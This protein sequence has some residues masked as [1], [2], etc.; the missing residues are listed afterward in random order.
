VRRRS[1]QQRQARH[2]GG[3]EEDEE[4]EEQRDGL[5]V[6]RNN[7][8]IDPRRAEQ[9]ERGGEELNGHDPRLAAA[10]GGAVCRVDD[11][12]PEELE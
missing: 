1:A 11:R 6:S 7:A 8:R 4:E 10:E 9:H 12:R 2:L 3:G 5:H